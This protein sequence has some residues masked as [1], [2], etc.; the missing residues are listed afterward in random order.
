MP[1]AAGRHGV[2]MSRGPPGWC[3]GW[4]WER[5]PAELWA[6]LDAHGVEGSHWR[7]APAAGVLL[8]S[9]PCISPVRGEQCDPSGA[10]RD[11]RRFV[12]H[13]RILEEP[14]RLPVPHRE[15]LSRV[16]RRCSVLK[17][18]ALNSMLQGEIPEQRR[19]AF[20][21]LESSENIEQHGNFSIN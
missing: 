20:S 15:D 12:S 16:V 10:H 5:P 3:R 8:Q 2:R 14:S 18:S 9:L 17:T 1:G 6:L 7:G 21:L 4:G 13:I 11:L 19:L